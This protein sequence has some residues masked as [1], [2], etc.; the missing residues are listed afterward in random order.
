MSYIILEFY[1]RFITTSP[2]F[3]GWIE[4]RLKDVNYQLRLAHLETLS[5][6]DLRLENIDSRSHV[7]IVDLVLKLKNRLSEFTI[8][9][10]ERDR[11]QVQLNNVMQSVDEELRTILLSNGGLRE[12]IE[13]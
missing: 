6:A 7:E 8:E 13:L 9:D 1:T 2:N 11:I 4:E 5:T 10:S 12:V 3:K